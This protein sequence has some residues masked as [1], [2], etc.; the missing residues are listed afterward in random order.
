MSTATL[1]YSLPD[2]A[3]E[4]DNATHATQWRSVVEEIDQYLRDQVKFGEHK[5]PARAALEAARTELFCMIR[6]RG[7]RIE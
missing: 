1:S 7:L 3:E 6:D 2:E 4:F 5:R